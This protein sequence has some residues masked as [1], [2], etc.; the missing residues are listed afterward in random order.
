[1]DPQT[2]AREMVQHVPH[3]LIPDLR[4]LGLPIKLGDTPGDIRM[5]PPLLGQHT[6]EVLADL[7]YSVAEMS[8]LRERK[9]I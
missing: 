9:A 2:T 3:P 6:E 5:P 1:M 7:G 8:A 4:L